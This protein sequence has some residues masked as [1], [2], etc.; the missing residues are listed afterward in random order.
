MFTQ[1]KVLP[2]ILTFSQIKYYV[3]SAGFVSLAVFMPWFCHQFQ[4]AGPKFLP[5]HFFVL[6]AG[7]LFGWRTG[8]IV[9]AIS[10]LMSYGISH[11]PPI[12]ILPETVLELA[13]YGFLIGILREKGFNVW[14]ALFFAMLFG[15][16]A[17]LL[18]VLGFG[19]ETNPMNY[20]Q[21]SWPG[22]V[23]QLA[24]IPLI[25]YLLQKFVFSKNEKAI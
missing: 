12:A 8:L 6:I 18:L 2:K 17:R 24:L 20:F 22:I 25:I 16:L 10:P 23:L 4:L 5:M 21:I 1:A 14:V 19:L 7:F 15:R 3:F 13:C 9:G 11:M